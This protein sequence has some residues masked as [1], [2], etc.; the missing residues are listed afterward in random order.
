M[1]FRSTSTAVAA[2]ALHRA[3]TGQR[4]RFAARRYDA[5]ARLNQAVAGLLELQVR[6]SNLSAARHQ[7]RSGLFFYAMLAAQTAVISATF[8][9]A[10]A[11][12]K[13]LWAASITLGLGGIAFGVYVFLAV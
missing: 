2:E 13:L 8:S 12:R 4:L 10:S 3:F 1:L 11:W 9:L 5:E 6:Q 7:K